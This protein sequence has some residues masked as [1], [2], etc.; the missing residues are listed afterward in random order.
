MKRT[1]EIT[2]SFSGTISTGQFEN[3]RPMFSLKDTIEV[4]GAK[5]ID[6]K[7]RKR[8]EQLHDMCYGMFKEAERKSIV[9]RIEKE[10]KDIRFYLCPIHK[11]NYPSVTSVIGWDA[12]FYI[13]TDEL[14]Q[15]AAQSTIQHL[16]FN[17][18]IEKNEWIEPEKIPEAYKYIVIV[19]KGSLRLDYKAGN[20]PGFLE[21]YPIKF[22]SSEKAVFN[23]EYKYAGRPDADGEPLQSKEWEKAGAISVPTIFDVKRT[24]DKVKAFKQMAAYAKCKGNSKVKQ[25]CIIPIN[26]YYTR[27]CKYD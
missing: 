16:I 20:I 21:K 6:I 19:K 13:S 5:D 24:A 3:E 4:D 27:I 22:K 26:K 17:H 10:R 1:I 9:Q 2:S 12:D 7:I 18:F 15:Y 23:H 14:N 11:K 8:Q 25:L